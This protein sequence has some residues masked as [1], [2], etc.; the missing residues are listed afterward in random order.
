MVHAC[1][2]GE[3]AS[4]GGPCAPP[5]GRS[6][7]IKNKGNSEHGHNDSALPNRAGSPS[8]GAPSPPAWTPTA[9]GSAGPSPASPPWPPVPPRPRLPRRSAG[10]LAG[11]PAL[12]GGGGGSAGFEGRSAS[13]AA[14]GAAAAAAPRQRR[15]GPPPPMRGRTRPCHP[16]GRRNSG[17]RACDGSGGCGR[18]AA[19]TRGR[20][21]RCGGGGGG[22]CSKRR[23]R[24]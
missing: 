4:T 21:R 16:R 19:A 3:R 23:R 22:C 18:S 2:G 9:A 5:L 17:G 8:P 6:K 15:Q 11:P 7:R 12:E 14:P 10:P 1:C 13:S 24:R 20:C